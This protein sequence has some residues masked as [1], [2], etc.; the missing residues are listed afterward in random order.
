MNYMAL[1]KNYLNKDMKLIN[2]PS[3]RKYKNAVLKYLATKF[4][5]GI[6]YSEKEVGAIIDSNCLFKD[7]AWLR[8][9]LFG[10]GFLGRTNDGT[11][12]WK[13]KIQPNNE[14]L[15]LDDN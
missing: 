15:G 5:D 1:I 14:Y 12:Y 4:E 11:L 8:R 9:E 13:E 6:N 3:K 7:S 2:Y 10:L